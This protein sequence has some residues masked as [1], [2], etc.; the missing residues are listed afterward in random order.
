MVNAALL[1]VFLFIMFL[2]LFL[3]AEVD[4]LFSYW[5]LQL[6]VVCHWN[7]YSLTRL[8]CSLSVK[9]ELSIVDCWYSRIPL[10]G[11][12]KYILGFSERSPTSSWAM[13]LCCT[14]LRPLK[15]E[16]CP[17]HLSGLDGSCCMKVDV[18]FK[19]R[20]AD[21][22]LRCF[23]VS[24]FA[25]LFAFLILNSFTIN[26]ILFSKKI[27]VTFFPLQMSHFLLSCLFARHTNERVIVY[28]DHAES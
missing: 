7:M 12:S 4:P 25:R 1:A 2:V 8:H 28:I 24:T 21:I 26:E 23:Y 11:R 18:E 14:F 22:A 19:I 13:K 16:E 15:I 27:L 6:G 10:I 5:M 3:Q 9:I 20:H 17:F